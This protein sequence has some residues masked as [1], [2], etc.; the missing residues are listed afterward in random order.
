MLDQNLSSEDGWTN[1]PVVS[2]GKEEVEVPSVRGAVK[3]EEGKKVAPKGVSKKGEEVEPYLS[4]NSWRM[5]W[6]NGLI[7]KRN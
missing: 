2:T 3:G 7:E 4:G 5:G 6:G 1:T